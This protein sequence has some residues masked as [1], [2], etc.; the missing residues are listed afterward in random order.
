MST[1]KLKN[2]VN[3]ELVFDMNALCLFEELGFSLSDLETNKKQFSLIRG[4]LFCGLQSKHG[5][6]FTSVEIVGTFIDPLNLQ[7][8]TT[9]VMEAFAKAMGGNTEEATDEGKQAEE[10]VS[11]TE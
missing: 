9:Q 4:L 11:P 6:T 5:S 2:D 10:I 8:T 1:V 3:Y 7:G